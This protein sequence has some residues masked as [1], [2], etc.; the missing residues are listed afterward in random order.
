MNAKLY[1]ALYAPKD[2]YVFVVTYGRS[3]ST[4]TQSLLNSIP[5][6]C[7]RGE[8][9]NL[10]YQLARAVSVTKTWDNYVWR[11]TDRDKPA[12]EQRV[13][14]KGIL[15]TPGDPW[16]G[17]ENVDPL[18]FSRSLANVFV[19]DVLAPPKGTR[20]CGFK[21]IRFHEDKA[22]FPSYLDI[23]KS[24]FPKAR[25]IFQ[26][27]DP[28]DV[29]KSSWWGSRKKSDVLEMIR[30]A[31]MLFQSFSEQNPDSCMTVNYER[32]AE[33]SGYV[34]ELFDFLGESV[35]EAAVSKVLDRKLKH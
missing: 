6:Y 4:L 28:E 31:E 22:F 30:N 17:A 33:G 14:L 19:R 16:Y 7:I 5:G 13:F 8:N 3:G 15:G 20:V 26:T 9:G 34:S 11:R 18:H 12:E 24:S 21:E 29:S 1:P 2:G 25:F 27:R 23:I 35:D 10:L 32:Y